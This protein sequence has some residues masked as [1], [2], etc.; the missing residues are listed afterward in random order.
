MKLK[1]SL[2]TLL[3]LTLGFMSPIAAS[4]DSDVA[5]GTSGT[6]HVTGTEVVSSSNCT[7]S[8]VIDD[9]ITSIGFRA[10]DN[11]VAYY[12]G[13][14]SRANITS[15]TLG[16]SV[17]RIESNAF[18]L[19]VGDLNSLVIPNSVTYIGASA[20]YG[21][22]SLTTLNLGTGVTQ[23]SNSAFRGT[24]ALT[25]LALPPM[26]NML[27]SNVFALSGITSLTV[28]GSL[29]VI[30]YE[31]LAGMS[32]LE[33]LVLS[34]GVLEIEDFAISSASSLTSLTLPNSLE[35]IGTYSFL[36]MSSL[37]ELVV[38][39][40][41]TDIGDGAFDMAYDLERLIV[42]SSVRN[43]GTDMFSLG[44]LTCFTNRSALTQMELLQVDDVYPACA[45]PQVSA[46]ITQA[47][48]V[49]LGPVITG[50]S[51]RQSST[52]GGETLSL[53]GENLALVTAVLVA[54]TPVK[55]TAQNN[56]GMSILLPAHAAGKVSIVLS[57]PL[58][59]FRFDSAIE[60]VET[61]ETPLV[62]T[63]VIA[64]AGK[65]VSV[66]SEAQRLNVSQLAKLSLSKTLDC[67][68]NY[69]NGVPGDLKI[70]KYLASEACALAKSK[71][72]R[73]RTTMTFSEKTSSFARTLTLKFGN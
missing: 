69:A 46:P 59:I 37:T 47:A 18:R 4:A 19:S 64:I 56:G 31:S 58:A 73:L 35:L 67:K 39:N 5:C 40:G 53:S 33:T 52:L 8:V 51:T 66:L 48:N 1:L 16:S 43:V 24:S 2:T 72:P 44:S 15:L 49:Y 14:D 42:G 62:F 55:I 17:Q 23:I 63:R 26:L 3:A 36:G 45:A 70:A 50:L 65:R 6:Y 21:A 32:S 29:E 25:Q 30:P 22:G 71:N 54:G 41:V 9:T 27:G 13:T 20:F 28:P 68:V 12:G 11:Q 34:E 10:F 7:G 61:P 60:F 57:S 38:P